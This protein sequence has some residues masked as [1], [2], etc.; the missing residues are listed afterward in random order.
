MKHVNIAEENPIQCCNINILGSLNVLNASII[1]QI[2][3]TIFIS[4]DKACDPESVYGKSKSLIEDC[5]VGASNDITKFSA[6][7]FA[8]VTHSNGSVL[9]FWL[10]LK[11]KNMPLKLTDPMMNRLMFSQDEAASLIKKSI[12]LCENEG[13]GFV[14]SKK[15]KNVNMFELAKSISD[16]VEITEKRVG[17]KLNETLIN[18]KE[19]DFSYLIDD[20]YIMLKKTKNTGENK[21][22]KEFSS[23]TADKMNSEELEKLIKP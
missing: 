17:E 16:N 15:M 4:T 14:L 10:S 7:R 6:C 22:N 18:E 8:N 20:N 3:T 23:L 21:L 9:P 5:F 2:P 12:D 13:G 1:S 11:E 19:I